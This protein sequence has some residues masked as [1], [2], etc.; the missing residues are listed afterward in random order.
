[1]S[2][3]K[4]T[5]NMIAWR[6]LA[7]L[8]LLD[9]WQVAMAQN[10][11]HVD[12][13]VGKV[14][15]TISVPVSITN[16][17]EIVAAQFDITLPFA[18]SK[19]AAT[20]TSRANGHSLSTRI[21][22]NTV[23]V[24]LMSM[25]NK[26]LRGSS[27][28][29]LRLP[30]TSYDDGR[31][32]TPY[33][34]TISNIVLADRSG[35]N[36]AT[37]T[38]A[39]S[40]FTASREKLP[41]L[42][43]GEVNILTP[44]MTPGTDAEF[45]YTIVNAGDA[46]TEAGWTTRLYLESPTTGVRTY[47]TSQSYGQTMAAGESVKQSVRIGLPLALH[48]DGS[49][50]AVVEVTPQAGC[51]EL[52][53]DQDNN[54]GY[55]DNAMVTKRLFLSS[56]RTTVYEGYPNY[57]TLTL[58]RTGDW[59]VNETYDVS[60]SVSGLFS[61]GYNANVLPARV[62]IPAGAS[63]TTFRIYSVDDNIVRAR[64]A[65][66]SVAGAYGYD[67]VS[68]RLVR[69][70]DDT[71]PLSLAASVSTMT[72]GEELTLTAT[73]GGE[74]IDELELVVQC[75]QPERFGPI[76]P[77]YFEAGQSVA[78]VKVVATDNDAEQL[79]G[80]VRFTVSATDYQTART[81]VQLNDD[82][83]P[84]I[85]LALSPSIVSETAGN[86][87]TTLTVKREGKMDHAVRVKI[88][89]DNSEVFAGTSVVEIPAGKS[90]VEV[91]IGVND[92]ER[93]DASRRHTLSAMLYL[94]ANGQF[95]PV[96]DRAYSSAV[97][98]VTDDE[99][100]YLSLASHTSVVSEGQAST[101]TV[102]RTMASYSGSMTVSLHSNDASC[103]VPASVT[104]PAGYAAVS[105]TVSVDRNSTEDDD[106]TVTITAEASDIESA[107]LNLN[108]TDRTLPDA[109]V[110]GVDHEGDLYAGV[111]ATFVAEVHNDGT[112]VLP[113]E[114]LVDFLLSNY[115]Y[116]YSRASL[117]S[118]GAQAIGR[119]LAVGETMTVTLKARVPEMTGRYWLYAHVNK[120]GGVKEF[121]SGNNIVPHFQSV[122]IAA[123]FSV[124]EVTTAHEDYLPGEDVIVTGRMVGRLNG[125]SVRIRL[126]GNGQNTTATTQIDANGRF[127]AHVK[128]DRS[129][130][131]LMTVHATA[132]GQ[133][134]A[135]KTATINVVSMGLGADMTR[136]TCDENIEKKGTIRIYNRSS[137]PVTGVTLKHGVLPY[138]C[139]LL[140]GD[141]PQ[142]ITAGGY[143]DVEYTIVPSVAM[144]GSQYQE[145]S[146]MTACEEGASAEIHFT[147]FCR[148]TDCNLSFSVSPLNT[149]LLLGG[150]RTVEL[151]I[152]NYGLKESGS[153][154]L[155]I[156]TDIKWLSSLSPATLPSIAP[157]TS[158]TIRLL[159][160]HNSTMHS[161]RTYSSFMRV[162]PE[163][164][165]T[166]GLNINVKVV[167]TE[168]SHLD[169]F[170]A[171]VYSLAD[172]DF[173]K[174]AGGTVVVTDKRNGQTVASGTLDEEGHWMT[175]QITEGTYMLSVSQ[176]RHTT[177]TRTLSIGPG[178]NVSTSVLLPYKAVLTNFVTTQDIEDNSY[179]MVADIDIDTDA[180]QAIVVPTLSAEGFDCGT[181]D[182]DI[183]LK[184][185]GS[186]QA[187][188]PQFTFPSHIEGATF[189]LQNTLPTYLNPGETYVLKVRYTGPE[190]G[191]R[192]VIATL[193]MSYSFSIGG[194]T[195]S[196]TDRYQQLVG[197][198]TPLSDDDEPDAEE[199]QNKLPPYLDPY[200][201]A[202]E[203]YDEGQNA[204]DGDID[205]DRGHGPSTSLPTDDSWYE[206]V[207]EE[208]EN[209]RPG[210][211]VAATLHVHNGSM[212]PM[213]GVRFIPT[214]YDYESDEELS[215]S[216]NVSEGEGIGITLTEGIYSIEAMTDGYLPLQFTATDEILVDGERKVMIGGNLAYRSGGI[217]YTTQLP[218]MCV[219]IRPVGR[220]RVTYL[221]QHNFFGDDL[222]T[223]E[224]RESTE[225]ATVVMVVQNVGKTALENV[226]IDSPLPKVVSNNNLLTA[227]YS[228]LYAS[229]DGQQANIDLATTQVERLDP[230]ELSTMMWMFASDEM[231]HVDN[232]DDYAALKYT[233]R[234]GEVEI[235]VDSPH[236]LVRG[237]CTNNYNEGGNAALLDE[238]CPVDLDFK[239]ALAAQAN[240]FLLNDVEDE[241]NAPDHV[242]IAADDN[243][244]PVE[245][246]SQAITLTGNSGTYTLSLKAKQPG[247]VYGTLHDPTNG[248]MMLTGV[249]RLSDGAEVSMANFWQTDRII[250]ADYSLMSSY[251]L[252]F[253]DCIETAEESYELTF[254]L[255]PNARLDVMAVRLYTEEGELVNVGE[256]TTEPIVKATIE[257]TKDI[258]NLF[259]QAIVFVANG[260]VVNLGDKP[261]TRI[262]DSCYDINLA[263]ADKIYPGLHQLTILLSGVKEKAAPRAAGIGEVT[264]FWTE[265]NGAK[266]HVDLSVAPDTRQGKLSAE[267]GDY[268]FGSFHVAAVS[269]PG[270]AFT[271]WT[272][273]GRRVEASAELT[274]DLTDDVAIRAHFTPLT[275]RMEVEESEHGDI[276]GMVS[277][278][279]EGG[280]TVTLR[281]L[282]KEGYI[283]DGWLVNGEPAEEEGDIFKFTLYDHVNIQAIFADPLDYNRDGHVGIGDIPSAIARG[284]DIETIDA[285]SRRVLMLP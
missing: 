163:N 273:N 15:K 211:A 119:E 263:A 279:Y 11:L 129:A 90:S 275:Y 162:A 209:V 199:Q 115:D 69:T 141:V 9:I 94:P 212:R 61:L 128:I 12:P 153:V 272:I 175:D 262:N 139:E 225:P 157:G 236:E 142:T 281:A 197:C 248:H 30:M 261:V 285:I 41:D 62:T 266:V 246:V 230:S 46:P 58:L 24:V 88:V 14:G 99:S 215:E 64:E 112:A 164:G 165:A 131:G 146:L 126:E 127:M 216:V 54:S 207:F 181:I 136:L 25:G 111:E 178:E 249:K 231:A 254:T 268:D 7:L 217:G 114:T 247:W 245:N 3:V 283:F 18:P 130:W 116:N 134:E 78:S 232:I 97:L 213:T 117:T 93:V 118:I 195:L 243:L 122:F 59:S 220:M 29:V 1:M 160:T 16:A 35:K 238:Y 89:T 240:A 123:P 83:R 149:T 49:V 191:I 150:S 278:I 179:S 63:A 158:T 92:N 2:Q 101:M 28:I 198:D 161:G 223:E 183:V 125:Q 260:Q 26:P 235:E 218:E 170:A 106:R 110:L 48:V 52:I 239:T 252:H 70:D 201:P 147:Y 56:D 174:L 105:F 264:V 144:T 192:R 82:D 172:N 276:L 8:L 257:F 190:N 67:G 237:I 274:Y 84:T 180:P 44:T 77:L 214:A 166:R 55:S 256:T 108:I 228:G 196:E 143:A 259:N 43:V 75:S 33:P 38:S 104:I 151:T 251:D 148:A 140:L 167:G 80:G 68:C 227:P 100:P 206:L 124:E 193:P 188:N 152:T 32:A 27:G 98:T 57:A 5:S 222:T 79:D 87:A 31:T 6:M 113:K 241:D 176:N 53:V 168:F 203:N 107:T 155:N 66:V 173:S 221:V 282:P 71:N 271:Y 17:D 269:E 22:G 34:V 39:S 73:R 226:V 244:L 10:T 103:K 120:D 189:E 184:N 37:E 187:L 202:P 20:L 267:S 185:V 169:V 137:K 85:T 219:T 19:N 270:Y 233:L 234:G 280:T 91:A 21:N 95:A 138:G 242:L 13:F 159:L 132:V 171:D 145:F 186:R 96:G 284:A 86:N 156:P 255:L 265:N 74:L 60:A 277:G 50:R 65:E 210:Q 258:K 208:I 40:T 204:N 51:G 42:T 4:K 47:V 194:R 250:A 200:V 135:E 253:A 229:R 23:S 109:T 182:A 154:A 224:K 102:S 205:G 45:D 121:S 177:V 81:T 133:T 76:P 72:E 36:I